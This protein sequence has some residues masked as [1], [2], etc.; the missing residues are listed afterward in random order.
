MQNLFD[1]VIIQWDENII[2]RKSI[3]EDSE[4]DIYVLM[5][6][7]AVVLLALQF[8]TNRAYSL[9]C[10]SGAKASLTFTCLAGLLSAIICA[11]I[12]VV[13]EGGLT[14][15]IYSI[16]L[17]AIVAVLCSTYNFIGFK[18]MALGSLSVFMMFL[19]LGGM[20]LPYLFGI[21][22]LD[23][24]V[25]VFRIIGLVLL[26]VSMAFPVLARRDTDGNEKSKK[27][28]FIFFILCALV[29]CLNGGVSIA[30][31][32]HQISAETHETCSSA[33]FSVISNSISAVISGIALIIINAF[34]KNRAE[35]RNTEAV[36]V[37]KNVKPGF[38]A[39]V[40]FGQAAFGGISYVLQLFSASHVDASMLYP[41]ITGGSV[42]LSALAGFVFFREKP[43]RLSFIGLAISFA[44]TFF[45]LF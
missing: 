23:E 39:A 1:C 40:T 37:F 30:S 16:G 43:D 19:M 5:I 45:F 11:F 15:P 21:F 14:F 18:I 44:A 32:I 22:Y 41:M 10:G 28:N 35:K 20:M 17:A 13:F 38:I 25:S 33:N 27:T 8:S 26:V 12:A 6:L 3:G 7:A 24:R 29:F 4:M 36:S 2:P 42:V 31:K 34:E 9:K